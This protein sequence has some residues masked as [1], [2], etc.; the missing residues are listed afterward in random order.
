MLGKKN[1][2]ADSLSR[3]PIQDSKNTLPEDDNLDDFIDVD[4]AEL[5]TY[6]VTSKEG[7]EPVRL[8]NDGYS[9]ESEKIARYLSTL[10]MPPGID[11]S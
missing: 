1:T 10:H 7:V 4:V 9:E 2:I 11:R 3:R 8:L 5:I 6:L